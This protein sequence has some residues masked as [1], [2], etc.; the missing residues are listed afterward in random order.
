MQMRLAQLRRKAN[1]ATTAAASAASAAA[2]ALGTLTAGTAAAAG[3]RNQQAAV[4]TAGQHLQL[5][6][7]IRTCHVMTLH[8]SKPPA[9]TERLCHSV[10]W[11]LGCTYMHPSDSSGGNGYSN[12]LQQADKQHR[13]GM[14][15]QSSGAWL[16]W[17]RACTTARR[18]ST[19][20]PSMPCMCTPATCVST[21]VQP[22]GVQLSPHQQPAEWLLTA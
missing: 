7:D 15:R 5:S 1:A 10:G 6:T 21:L 17:G 14:D 9:Q 8:M 18:P 19:H 3:V 13:T 12:H 11:A 22:T 2:S 16:T 20:T 4:S